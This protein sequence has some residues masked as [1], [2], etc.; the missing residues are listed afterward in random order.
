MKENISNFINEGMKGYSEYVLYS[1]AF[2]NLYDGLKPVQRR[3]LWSMYINNNTR[4]TKSANIVGD[5]YK[6]HPHGSAYGSLVNMVTSNKQFIQPIEG[7]GTFGDATS[8]VLTE[9]ADR[10]TESKLG[11]NSVIYLNEIKNNGVEYEKTYD[12]EKEI[13]KVFPVTAPMVLFNYSTGIGV[14]FS[15]SILPMNTKEIFKIIQNKL[16][17]KKYKKTYPDFPNGCK[18]VENEEELNNLYSTGK[19]KFQLVSDY[20]IDGNEIVIKAIP[21]NVSRETIIKEVRDLGK[22]KIIP[23]IKK[24][25]D[26]TGLNNFGISIQVKRDPERVAKELLERTSMSKT[27]SANMN[28]ISDGSFLQIGVDEILDKWIEWRKNVINKEIKSYLEKVNKEIDKLET[29]LSVKKNKDKIIPIIT[30]SKNVKKDLSKWYNDEQIKLILSMKLQQLTKDDEKKLLTKLNE[31]QNLIG[32]IASVK[33]EDLIIKA[34]KETVPNFERRSEIISKVNIERKKVDTKKQK[35]EFQ[36]EFKNG[37]IIKGKNKLN[38]DQ[39]FVVLTK[40]NNL[41]TLGKKDIKNNLYVTDEEVIFSDI[42][43]NNDDRELI[44][45]FD[46][47]QVVKLKYSTFYLKKKTNNNFLYNNIKEINPKFIDGTKVLLKK[48]RRSRGA[49]LNNNMIKGVK[50]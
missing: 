12:G 15:T 11:K 40:N 6:Y 34:Y 36:F 3:I 38:E 21:E 44:V 47:D 26:E 10:Y 49:K 42:I 43:S 8:S 22:E 30:D 46:D 18:I 31:L 50:K 9:A 48:S 39:R 45:L 16:K 2:P 37:Y 33:I 41:F 19:A 4:F 27:I 28:V 35:E 14:G 24:V 5:V 13:V 23:E 1:R 29:I 17:G 7:Q 20:Y 32:S 25:S